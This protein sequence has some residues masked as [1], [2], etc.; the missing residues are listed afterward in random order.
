MSFLVYHRILVQ[1]QGRLKSWILPG[2]CLQFSQF[3]AQLANHPNPPIRHRH[4]HRHR[5]PPIVIVVVIVI[6]MLAIFTILSS[7]CQPKS[8]HCHQS[9]IRINQQEIFVVSGK[10]SMQWSLNGLLQKIPSVTHCAPRHSLCNK[11][12]PQAL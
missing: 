9:E 11:T 7:A 10:R 4:R 8:A 2:G 5:H 12:L 6:V 3:S 1:G